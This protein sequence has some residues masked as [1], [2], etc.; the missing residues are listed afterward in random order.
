MKE[1]TKEKIKA[2]LKARKQEAQERF[3][4]EEIKGMTDQELDQEIERVKK[5]I[6]KEEKDKAGKA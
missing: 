2:L 4:D 1:R 6:E 5:E 3:E